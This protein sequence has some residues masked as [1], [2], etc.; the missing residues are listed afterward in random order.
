MVLGM[1]DT[2]LPP[3]SVAADGRRG[4]STSISAYS[5]AP[6]T[7]KIVPSGQVGYVLPGPNRGE[8][9]CFVPEW[10]RRLEGWEIGRRTG[11][12]DPCLSLHE[13]ADRS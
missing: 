6:R 1:K 11:G 12:C 2:P 8:G 5:C 13:S 10:T 7:R 9:V 3:E 4:S